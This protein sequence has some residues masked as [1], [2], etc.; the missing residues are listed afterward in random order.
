MLKRSI[1]G[2]VFVLVI[3]AFFLLRAFVDYRLFYLLIAF[4]CTVGT[5]EVGRCL[6]NYYAK[7][8]VAVITAFGALFTPAYFIAELFIPNFAHTVALSTMV[9]A[10]ILLAIMNSKL[11]VKSILSTIIPLVYPS[12]LLLFFML[13]NSHS[14]GFE[15]LILTFVISPLTDT[16][17]YL[18][19]IAYNKIR[20]GQA[21]KLC[22]KL[23]P[24]KTIAGAIGGL[25]GGVVGAL[26]IYLIFGTKIQGNALPFYLI[27]GAVASIFTQVGD[28]FESYIKRKVGIKDI[29]KIMPGHG[30][31]MDR[32]DGITFAG[33]FL[34]LVFLIV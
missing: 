13:A 17:A 15:I 8:S 29:G 7:G 28:L 32:I 11:G 20:K 23:S 24:K 30:G 6:K 9:L 22:P 10:F 1:S 18:I 4:L 33:V 3:T 16:F 26:L 12:V 14:L 25:V 34:Y 27:A 19:G 5:F 2:S 21:K 31:V